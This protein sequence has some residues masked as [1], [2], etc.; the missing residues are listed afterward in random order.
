MSMGRPAYA[1]GRRRRWPYVL[2]FILVFLVFVFVVADRISA[3]VAQDRVANKLAGQRPFTGRPKVRIR[4]FPFL[5]QAG[6]GHYDDI[7]VSGPGQP[8][9]PLGAVFIVAQL[10]GVHL[11]VSQAA[12]GGD[13]PVPVDRADVA[14]RVSLD[15][16]AAASGVDSLQLRASGDQLIARAPVDVPGLGSV[17]VEA[18][19][20][21]AP[22][23]GRVVATLTSVR[24]VS[25]EL[26]PGTEAA[27]RRALRVVVPV[28]GLPFDAR[29]VSV[30][31]EG[32]AV[33]IS[34]S[35]TGVVLS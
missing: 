6:R 3:S 10:H 34:G 32:G 29:A 11:P 7:E 17:D 12:S 21:L 18:T 19:G 4:G 23:G 13:D 24:G 20:A 30:T 25:A 35:A 27:V 26:P 14:V 9:G 2:V 5:V 22:A 31:V 33:V 15:A 28:A 8:V 16:L 1:G